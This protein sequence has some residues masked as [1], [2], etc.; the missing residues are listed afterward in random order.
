MNAKLNKIYP[1]ATPGQLA[2][3][4]S[5]LNTASQLQKKSEEWDEEHGLGYHLVTAGMLLSGCFPL[6]VFALLK[7]FNPYKGDADVY[8]CRYR[9][10]HDAIAKA[11]GWPTFN[12]NIYGRKARKPRSFAN[13]KASAGAAPTRP[14]PKTAST[15]R[16]ALAL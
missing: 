14:A 8:F 2:A 11:N 16:P 9:Q 10:T 12:E 5:D 13:V 1:T 4:T 3:M 15:Q 7:R 6:M